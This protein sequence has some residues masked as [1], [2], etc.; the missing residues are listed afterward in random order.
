MPLLVQSFIVFPNTLIYLEPWLVV[1]VQYTPRLQLDIE[2]LKIPIWVVF[3][4]CMPFP[5]LPKIVLLEILVVVSAPSSVLSLMSITA[6][7]ASFSRHLFIVT[8][9]TAEQIMLNPL[10]DAAVLLPSMVIPCISESSDIV[11]S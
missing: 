8:P 9:F 11:I 1:A 2:L 5:A 3:C 10:P 6:P 7:I 4:N